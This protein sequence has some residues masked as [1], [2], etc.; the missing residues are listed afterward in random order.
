MND[1]LRL[2]FFSRL[3]MAIGCL[4]RILFNPAFARRIAAVYRPRPELKPEPKAMPAPEPVAP[5]PVQAH[6]SGLFLLSMLQREGRLIDFLQENIAAYSDA[7]VGAAARV[8]HE[9]CRKVVRQY[10]SLEPVLSD[11][12]G[13]VVSIPAGFDAQR[14]RLTGNVAG[15]PPFHGALRHHGWAAS[16]VKLPEVPKA[17]DPTIIAPAEV[18]LS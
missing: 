9:G 11:A 6:A 17:I 7:E 8:V 18:E 14:I 16:A 13:A 15:Q 12:E 10:I 3:V 5:P 4:F 2:S 1:E